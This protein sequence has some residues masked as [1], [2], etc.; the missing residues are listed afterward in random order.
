MRVP[1][2]DRR[3]LLEGKVCLITGGGGA[4][5]LASARLFLK[6]GARVVLADRNADALRTAVSV[7]DDVNAFSV[8]ADATSEDDVASLMDAVIE[9]HGQLDVVVANAGTPA[10]FGPITEFDAAE[11]DRTFAVHVR[12]VFL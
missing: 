11:F 3:N 1:G 2:P 10:A 12:S 9:R 6:E 8:T 4:I 7:L 5:G